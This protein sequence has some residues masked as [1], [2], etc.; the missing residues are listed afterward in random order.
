MHLCEKFSLVGRAA[1]SIYVEFHQL[2]PVYKDIRRLLIARP[3]VGQIGRVDAIRDY[4]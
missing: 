2:F 1:I 4:Q 3:G